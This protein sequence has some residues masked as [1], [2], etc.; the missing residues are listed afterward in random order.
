MFHTLITTS[1]LGI[2]D[3]TPV[4]FLHD[5]LEDSWFGL[6]AFTQANLRIEGHFYVMIHNLVGIYGIYSTS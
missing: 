1:C 6:E 3:N 2:Q 4:G 5:S